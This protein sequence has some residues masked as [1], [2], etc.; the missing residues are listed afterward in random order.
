VATQ[1]TRQVAVFG[2]DVL[3]AQCALTLAQL[4]VNVDV[5]TT[6]IDLRADSNDSTGESSNADLFRLRPL[7]LRAARH[8]RVEVHTNTRVEGIAPRRRG[9]ALRAVK[10]PRYVKTDLCTSCGQCTEV[11]SVEVPFLQGGKWLRHN[12]IH[13]PS[14]G[15]RSIPSAY[16]IDK[17]GVSPCTAGCPLGINVQGFVSLVAAGKVDKALALISEAAPLAGVLG[18]VC[19]HPCEEV[20]RRSEVDEAVFIRAL[21]RYAADNAASPVRFTRKA[22]AGARRERI[23][24]VGSGPAGL[25]CAWELARRGYTPTIFESHAVVGGML[26][27]G[28]P[29]FRLPREVREREVKAILDMG[30]EVRTGITVGRDVAIPDLRERGFRAFFVAIGAQENRELGIPGEDLEGVVDGMSLLFELNLK[31]GASVGRNMVV[32][33]GGNSAVDSARAARRRGR[34]NVTIIYRRTAEEMT[35][36]KEEVEE[37]INEGVAIEYLT[38]PVEILGDGTNVTGVRCQKMALGEPGP[39]GRREPVPIPGSE[40]VMEADHVVLAVGQRPSTAQLTKKRLEL[41]EDDTIVVDPITLVTGVP[42]V[43]AGGDCVTGPNSVVDAMAAGLR[44]AESIDRFVRGRS[45]TKGER[46]ERPQPADVNMADRYASPY[47]RAPMPFIPRAQRMGTFEETSLG[48]PPWVAEREAGR[49]LNCALCS[50]CL[51]CQEACQVGAVF[52]DDSTEKLE[53]QA[54]ALVEFV[55]GEAN[56][57]AY[58]VDSGMGRYGAPPAGRPGVYT[59]AVEEGDGLWGKLDLASAVAMRVA[60]Y[61]DLRAEKRLS[62]PETE[63]EAAPGWALAG[64]RQPAAPEGQPRTS[65]ILCHCGGS[66]SSVIDFAQVSRQAVGHPGIFSVE[67]IYQ[68]C[69][70]EG[71]RRI[72]AHAAAWQADR[73]VLAACRCCNQ[74]Q[75]CFSCTD[76]R[77]MCQH[78]LSEHLVL[79]PHGGVDFVNIREQC[80]WVHRNAPE[81]ATRKAMETIFA[82]VDRGLS[83]RVEDATER[84]I[85]GNVL[86]IGS[87][88][89]A[90]TAARSLVDRGHRVSLVSGPITGKKRPGRQKAR[91]LK[92]REDLDQQLHRKPVD[93]MPWPKELSL[94]GT[95]GQYE[96][97]LGYDTETVH[98]EAAAVIL[99]L[100]NEIGDA[101]EAYASVSGDSLLGR[102]IRHKSRFLGSEAAGP[103]SLMSI[104]IGENAGIFIVA[105]DDAEAVEEQVTKGEAAAAAAWSYLAQ[106]TVRPRT[107]SVSIN[108][109]L[110]RGCGDCT[111]VCPYIE[112]KAS[113][114]GRSSAYVEPAL[115]LGCGACLSL[116]PTGAISQPL[117]GDRQLTWVLGAL[118]G[119]AGAPCEVVV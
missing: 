110:C 95:P 98:V 105:L 21:H 20:C 92:A 83:D 19:T 55:S 45:L 114:G 67:Q 10:N 77:V 103:H 37:A 79:P 14:L 58:L 8:S 89:C 1:R 107:D 108:A 39:D 99:V 56:P 70:E 102:I 100:E 75:I 96:A 97:A 68:A 63:H 65:L 17:L 15:V 27:T 115:C 43:F 18:R 5:I 47:K 86:V 64:P 13:A 36:V 33:G 57:L 6:S 44:G 23:A 112:M 93:A 119:Q 26:A 42:D 38:S 16:S 91:Y 34:R 51:E 71:A 74:D 72:A 25:A 59:I 30:V 81:D 85:G 101:G 117:Q 50:G 60:A 53:M 22:G 29:R 62:E 24:I 31:V 61:L 3:A 7:L 46:V 111:T 35:A 84:P 87:S 109:R 116:C 82:A 12:A 90:L 66:I 118:L 73:L 9:Y 80:A 4:G 28:I 104:T 11:C 54:D 69:T 40:F 32:I 76:R 88:V 48:L 94:G 41:N 2:G 78:Y 52:H 49:C 106:G 113:E